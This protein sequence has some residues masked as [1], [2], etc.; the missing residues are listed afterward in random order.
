QTEITR[1]DL[2]G[3][4]GK[5]HPRKSTRA[6][7]VA[8]SVNIVNCEGNMGEALN[9]H[10]DVVVFPPVIP[11]GIFLIAVVLQRF[12][13]LHV[14]AGLAPTPRIIAGIL[15][16]ATGLIAVISA[17]R[18][19]ARRGT[20]VNP[21]QPTIAIATDGIYRSTRNPMYVGGMIAL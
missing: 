2:N 10:P 20:N 11:L 15:I 14:L 12:A 7:A 13:P 1:F 17:Q 8:L 18:A 5:Q 6:R 19:L 21:S 3:P 16:A 4:P 9:D